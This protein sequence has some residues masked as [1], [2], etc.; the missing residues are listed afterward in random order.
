[1]EDENAKWEQGSSFRVRFETYLLK[2]LA[3]EIGKKSYNL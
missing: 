1:M 3:I 2:F